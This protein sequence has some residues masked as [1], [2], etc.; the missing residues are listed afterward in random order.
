VNIIEVQ[1]G[2]VDVEHAWPVI[3]FEASPAELA[4]ME[5][6][7]NDENIPHEDVTSE[8][9]VEFR[10]IHYE[11]SLFTFPYFI[12]FEFPERA[13]ALRDFLDAMGDTANL[14]YFN[15]TSTGEQVGRALIGFEFDSEEDHAAFIKRLAE[16]GYQYH[17]T[18]EAVLRRVL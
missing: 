11:P 13:G 18:S 4:L 6:R 3:G 16:T 17:E 2:K 8:E 5:R 12:T 9:D 14:C 1:Y 10:I 15:Y 7:L